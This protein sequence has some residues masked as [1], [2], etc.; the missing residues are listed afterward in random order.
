VIN[1]SYVPPVHEEPFAH[2]VH[3]H[4]GRRTSVAYDD[5]TLEGLIRRD[6]QLL[7]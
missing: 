2:E 7:Y 1:D 4:S 5:R 3:M 6:T